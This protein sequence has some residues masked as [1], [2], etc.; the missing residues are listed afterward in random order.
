MD[1]LQHSRRGSDEL[2]RSARLPGR[3]P[4]AATNVP[5]LLRLQT[6]AGNRAA[7][8]AVARLRAEEIE[9]EADVREAAPGIGPAPPTD[10]EP[11]QRLAG[12]VVQRH[13]IPT[14]VV[15][16]SPPPEQDA[17]PR[18]EADGELQRQEAPAAAETITYPSY[19]D[20]SGNATISGA[21]STAWTETK[22]ATSD[23]S[24][25]EQGFWI[26]WNKDTAAMSKTGE[27][28]S[29]AVGNDTT[30]SVSLG[31]K[32]ADAGANYT[33]GSFHT[34]TPTTYRSVGRPIGASAA[35]GRADTSDNVTG[36]VYDYESPDGSGNIPKAHPLNSAAKLWHSGP[37][38]RT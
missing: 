31:A 1:R 27:V 9:P 19:A 2:E 8:L 37:N 33:V 10:E 5:P 23:G 6:L 26:R 24:R 16:P 21:S 35:D 29:P 32:P 15:G 38:R 17:G 30:A 28:I 34:H 4:A 11:V 36:L 18:R 14:D 20:V 3:P 12:D 25:R 22:A 13:R 7:T